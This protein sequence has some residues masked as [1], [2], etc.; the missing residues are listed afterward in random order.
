ML[1]QLSTVQRGHVPWPSG[2]TCFL[3]AA[4]IEQLV[5]P[6]PRH[7]LQGRR[8]KIS[9]RRRF[10]LLRRQTSN[11]RCRQAGEPFG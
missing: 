5:K 8:P 2:L 3:F 4:D 1:G 10:R 9:L 11:P 7:Q 6:V